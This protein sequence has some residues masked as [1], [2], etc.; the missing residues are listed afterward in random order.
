M[1]LEVGYDI[2]ND[3]YSY[4]REYS[5]LFVTQQRGVSRFSSL[6]RTGH[7]T[8]YVIA[9]K[10]TGVEINGKIYQLKD[11]RDE[12]YDSD[13][14]ILPPYETVI[15]ALKDFSISAQVTIPG[16]GNFDYWREKNG[17]SASLSRGDEILYRTT[18]QGDG[19]CP[20]F[21]IMI[22]E[23]INMVMIYK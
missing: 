3:E 23:L 1:V 10:K 8:R 17:K 14:E 15:Q 19:A 22:N 5:E 21:F 7:F 4:H 16:Y 18:D 12:G 11:L 20:E 2:S 13:N 6:V 9:S